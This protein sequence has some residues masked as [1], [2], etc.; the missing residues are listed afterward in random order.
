MFLNSELI[1][2]IIQMV[3]LQSKAYLEFCKMFDKNEARVQT[4][5]FMRSTLNSLTRA[6]KTE[7]QI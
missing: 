1:M 7:E 3:E 5:I 6:D 2:S 4:E